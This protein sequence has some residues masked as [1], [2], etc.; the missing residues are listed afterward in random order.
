[1]EGKLSR[2]N[3][4]SVW[5]SRMRCL[6]GH[7]GSGIGWVMLASLM[8]YVLHC[9]GRPVGEGRDFGSYW[10][11]FRDIWADV[12]E[13]PLVMLYRTPG[14]PLL[15]GFLFGLGSWFLVQAYFAVAYCVI[16]VV[17]FRLACHWSRLAGWLTVGIVFVST[18]FFFVFNTVATENPTS[19][20]FVLWA[21]YAW[22]IR[23]SKKVSAWLVF[24]LLSLVLVMIRPNHQILILA[25]VLPLLNPHLKMKRRLLNSI[26]FLAVFASGLLGYSGYNYARYGLFEVAHLTPA[27]LPFFRLF[28]C[29]RMIRPEHGPACAKLGEIVR[30]DVLTREPF[31]TYGIDEKTFWAGGTVRFW[32]HIIDAVNRRYGLEHNCAI[33]G[34]AAIEAMKRYPEVFW[35]SF[36]DQLRAFYE[37]P[38]R[39][40]LR[41]TKQLPENFEFLRGK[42]YQRYA[43]L[44]LVLPNE[45]DLIP[46]A[47]S[48]MLYQPEGHPGRVPAEGFPDKWQL[49][50]GPPVRGVGRALTLVGQLRPSAS[51]LI[52]FILLGCLAVRFRDWDYLYLCSLTG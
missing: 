19:V 37:F 39:G 42:C 47:V 50:S 30:E 20:M 31:V 52:G 11:Y 2:E 24:A 46:G 5:I 17:L 27:H 35:L 1:M 9:F 6:F 4:A 41:P 22:R 34:E 33:M 38:A 21:G 3:D 51:V 13:Y 16:N 48:H 45:N 43:D 23:R 25:M 14:A 12:P 15:F 49:R 28:A 29:S 7:G 44:G 18:E 32:A 36:Y 8:A 40:P 26:A 10:L